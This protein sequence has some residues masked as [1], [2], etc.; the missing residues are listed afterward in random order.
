[1]QPAPVSLIL[2]QNIVFLMRPLLFRSSVLT[3]LIYAP[4]LAPTQWQGPY[5][6][7]SVSPDVPA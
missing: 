6:T 1:L 3:Y 7:T 2:D 4:C 5:L